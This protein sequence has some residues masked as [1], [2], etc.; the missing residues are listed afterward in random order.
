MHSQELLTLKQAIEKPGAYWPWLAVAVVV[1]LLLLW[2]LGR[3]WTLPKAP[4]FRPPSLKAR[5]YHP[6]PEPV[7]ESSQASGAEQPTEQ[8]P[9]QTGEQSPAGE[10]QPASAE[11]GGASREPV[12]DKMPRIS[13]PGREAPEPGQGDLQS[14][15]RQSLERIQGQ[16][17]SQ[18]LQEQERGPEVLP[19]PKRKRRESQVIA[20]GGDM[21]L[22]INPDGSC[23]V[24][25]TIQGLQGPVK[26][27]MGTTGCPADG[28]VTRQWR[29]AIAKRL[30]RYKNTN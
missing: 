15:L 24:T 27:W 30:A 12:P 19:R 29:E 25:Q 2:G 6:P 21:E 14:R 11:P 22:H 9:T 13:L 3:H 8:A 10:S 4:E 28:R 18:W 7:A 20:M 26:V 23:A 16:A 5:L 17:Q 1:H